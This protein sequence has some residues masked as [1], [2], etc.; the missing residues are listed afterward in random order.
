[1]KEQR[2]AGIFGITNSE[3]LDWQKGTRKRNVEDGWEGGTMRATSGSWK[4]VY[5][6]PRPSATFGPRFLA[7]SVLYINGCRY[8]SRCFVLDYFWAEFSSWKYRRWRVYR[9]R[10]FTLSCI[11]DGLKLCEPAYHWIN[12]TAFERK[13]E[14]FFERLKNYCRWNVFFLLFIYTL[15]TIKS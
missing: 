12:M 11:N 9:Q 3:W 10:P 8:H 13:I 6:G 14:E 1:M 15:K 4:W 2:K 5:F 7:K